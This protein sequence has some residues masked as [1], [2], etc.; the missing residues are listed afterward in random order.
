MPTRR[1]LVQ[2]GLGLS[3][4]GVA[5]RLAYAFGATGSY[6]TIDVAG[7]GTVEGVVRFEGDRPEPDRIIIGKDNHVCGDGHV[8]PDPIKLGSD[9]GLKDAVVFIR[10]IAAGKKPPAAGEAKVVQE[11]CAFA[12]YVQVLPKGVELT[13]LN[14][15]PLLH[16]IHAYELI[17]RARRTLF[18]IAQPAAGQVDRHLLELRRGDIVE[19]DCDA[20][21]WMSAWIY[22]LDHPYHAIADSDGRFEIGEVPPG[23]YEIAA[24]HPAL[25]ERTAKVALDAKG[26]SSIDFRYS[27]E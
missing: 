15:D 27:A 3:A 21:N 24:W 2:I 7:G 12:P 26:K 20:H 1:D 19:I 17:G 14:K 9:G 10:N 6:K 11:D 4:G 8:T 22:T 16:N 23:A 5:M 25:G 13:I 18:N